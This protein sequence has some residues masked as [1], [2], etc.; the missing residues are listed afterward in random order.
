MALAIDEQLLELPFS[1]LKDP[2][3]QGVVQS[4]FCNHSRK[5]NGK[6]V[7]GC[8]PTP[9][10]PR[11]RNFL[12]GFIL[13]KLRLESNEGGD[14]KPGE[15]HNLATFLELPSEIILEIFK[16]AHPLDLYHLSISSQWL[17]QSLTSRASISVW[18]SSFENHEDDIPGPPSRLKSRPAAW[19][20]FLFGPTICEI[21]GS[22]WAELDLT[23]V[24]KL[25]FPCV[26]A[27]HPP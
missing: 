22:N 8:H 4:L 24:Q 18:E 25:C 14:R 10:H 11:S 1:K 17:R 9:R 12:R 19:A 13:R 20:D 15:K 6:N 27:Y 26:G 7:A 16:H 2:H 5:W 3:F 23:F 21:C